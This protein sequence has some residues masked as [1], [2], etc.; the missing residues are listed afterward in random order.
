M[1][2][3]DAKLKFNTTSSLSH[4]IINGQIGENLLGKF[5]SKLFIIKN[6]ENIF[7]FFDLN[8]Y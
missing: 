2:F 5:N 4:P 3:G 6:K 8:K 1:E 7:L